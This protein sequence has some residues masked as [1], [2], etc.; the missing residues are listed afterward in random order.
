MEA[1]ERIIRMEND[2]L[3]TA[4]QARQLRASIAPNTPGSPPP[5]PGHRRWLWP[6]LALPIA[7][8]LLY[9]AWPHSKSEEQSVQQTEIVQNVSQSMN[10]AGE[11]G[12]MNKSI[13][14]L[15]AIVIFLIVPVLLLTTVYNG[16]VN[17]EEAVFKNWAQVE[18][19]LQRRSDL[20]PALVDTVAGYVR[21]ER[22]T[23]AGVTAQRAQI[24]GDLKGAIDALAESQEMIA[25]LYA[26]DADLLESQ[27]RMDELLR[28]QATLKSRMSGFMAL[29][30]DYPEL[31][32]SD[33]FLELQ[34]QLEGTENRINVAR[35]RF[36]ESVNS[37]NAAIRRLPGTL[38]AG[39]GSFKRKAYFQA[40]EN[41]DQ[42]PAVNLKQQ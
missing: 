5:R 29:A 42:P 2:G 41:S 26:D 12:A 13:L 23:L 7:I 30:E 35:L 9:F 33:Q 24:Q 40:D 20:V 4:D 28:A 21:H 38:V 8:A 16:L 18:S 31:R 27:E 3:I 25:T 22:E 14:N 15:I 36:N 6:F 34:A 19:Q 1:E 11:T 39:M 37:Y 32:A 10:Q 17:R